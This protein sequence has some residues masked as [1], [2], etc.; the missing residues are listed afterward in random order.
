MVL[1][2]ELCIKCIYKHP[3]STKHI[4][5]EYLSLQMKRP[6]RGFNTNTNLENMTNSRKDRVGTTQQCMT[7]Q[8]PPSE[9]IC[10]SEVKSCLTPYIFFI[11]SEKANLLEITQIRTCPTQ[12]STGIVSL[13]SSVHRYETTGRERQSYRQFPAFIASQNDQKSCSGRDLES[14]SRRAQK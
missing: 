5:I 6:W 9:G 7:D 14:M 2:V 12:E 13:N 3:T 1:F 11:A 8:V 4:F 10:G